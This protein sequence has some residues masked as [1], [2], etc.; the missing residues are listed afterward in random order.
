VLLIQV[1]SINPLQLITAVFAARQTQPLY[2]DGLSGVIKQ[3]GLSLSR[4]IILIMATLLILP[5]LAYTQGGG[6][7]SAGGGSS[8]GQTQSRRSSERFNIL[9]FIRKQKEA[10]SAQDSKY[11]RGGGSSSGPYTD[12]VLTY[13]QDSGPVTRNGDKLGKDTRASGRLQ[14]LLDDLF[15]KGNRTRSLNIDLG[16]EGF[17]SQTTSFLV[18]PPST[19]NSHT[20]NEMGA[21][22]LIRPIGRSSQD[23]G[24]LVKAGYMSMNQ[25]GLWSNTQNSYSHYATYLGAEAKLYLLNF[26]GGRVEYQT[27]LESDINALQ[28]TWKMQRF[29]YGGFLEIYLLNI[30]ASLVSTEMILANKNTGAITKELYSGVSFSSMFHF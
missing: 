18:E 8:V 24:L 17:Y 15:T 26:L 7:A 21:A 16:V 22:L 4:Q 14:F 1:N 6:G 11:G 9:D 5:S 27:T 29:T 13:S 25:T 2:N 3:W 30:G 19:Q 12:F 10:T 28:S 20:Y 23:T